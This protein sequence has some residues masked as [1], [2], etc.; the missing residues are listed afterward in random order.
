MLS[1]GVTNVASLFS[2]LALD[3]IKPKGY[4]GFIIPKSFLTVSSWLPL[5][6]ILFNETL[7]LVSDMGMAFDEVG[8]EQAIFVVKKQN[9]LP[10]NQV[11]ISKYKTIINKIP[12]SFFIKKSIILTH[13]DKEKFNLIEK[14]EQNTLLLETIAD[15]PRGISVISKDFSSENKYNYIWVLGGINLKRFFIED[16][17]S[18]K[19]NRYLPINH[20][21]IVAKNEI[22]KQ[23]RI[24]YQ[25][26]AS[27]LPKIVATL[28]TNNLPTD[29]TVNNLVLLDNNFSYEYILALLNS[30]FFTFYLK[31]GIINK[32]V[33]TVHLD[34]P[35]VGKFPIKKIST[36][37]QEIFNT[38]INLLLSLYQAQ[39]KQNNTFYKILQSQF[40]LEKN[41]ERLDN[42][43]TM[44]WK[45]FTKEMNRLNATISP[46]KE[47]QFL[48]I[49]E[50]ESKISLQIF[51]QIQAI[52][53]E[54]NSCIYKLYDLTEEEITIIEN[55]K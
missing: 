22:F 46:K 45:D 19:P 2:K 54:I 30:N 6:K 25:N 10:D 40:D 26:I 44:K 20:D 17:A 51:K 39:N 8:L 49:F 16:G 23:K 41:S 29:D 1:N 4:V 12:Q 18:R 3:L 38:K 28:E 50:E 55:E 53:E 24:I 13:L 21:T 33:L 47:K 27:S 32:S 11:V 5:R 15:M 31:Y 37:E 42:W 43:Y 9:Y 14:V 34:K 48:E 7:K 36:Q 35:Y 52:K